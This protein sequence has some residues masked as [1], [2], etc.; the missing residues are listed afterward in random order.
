MTGQT[1]KTGIRQTEDGTTRTGPVS[2]E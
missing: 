1:C 2:V